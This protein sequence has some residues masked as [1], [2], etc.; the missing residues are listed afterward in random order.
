M[1]QGLHF[2]THK[3][4]ITPFDH[5]MHSVAFISPIMTIPQFY[6]IWVHRQ[7]AGVSL[8]SWTAWTVTSFLWLLYWREHHEIP[9]LVSQILIVILNI[10][11]VIGIILYK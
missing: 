3:K 8:T 6:D 1:L 2:H 11:I 4:P 7:V 9:I 10:G 5:I